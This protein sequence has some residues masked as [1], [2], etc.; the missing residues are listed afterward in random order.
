M[1]DKKRSTLPLETKID[2]K[3]DFKEKKLSP[4]FD[5]WLG[6][7]FV[8]EVTLDEEKESMPR[9]PPQN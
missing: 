1:S 6:S 7:E 5:L 9:N 4:S 3:R 2:A 8:E